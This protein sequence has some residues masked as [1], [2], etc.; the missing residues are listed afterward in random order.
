MSGKD[1]SFTVNYPKLDALGRYV[2]GF[3]LPPVDANDII[4]TQ[5]P[6][7]AIP[8]ASQTNIVFGEIFHPEIDDTC[9]NEEQVR[10]L[11]DHYLNEFS[12]H[13]VDKM[14]QDYSSEPTL[15]EVLD[16]KPATYH[17]KE[18]VRHFYKDIAKWTHDSVDLQYMAVN[19]N[20]AQVFWTGETDKHETIVG[21]DSFA[22][23]DQNHITSQTTV[24][25][26][27]DNNNGDNE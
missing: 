24:A 26:T 15:H 13:S 14:L 22:F 21:T 27:V 5:K 6:E 1:V 17:G 25:M 4:L 23:D 19:H 2:F 16:G 10:V 20:H 18:G 12:K 11:K 3:G 9:D 7:V 8:Q